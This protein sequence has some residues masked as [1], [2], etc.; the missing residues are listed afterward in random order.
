MMKTM[1][2]L[3]VQYEQ[4]TLTRRQLLQG[5]AVVV[6]PGERQA[7][8]G[9]LRGRNI[10]HVNLRVADVD[11]SVDFYRRLFSL[12][13]RRLIPGRPDVVDLPNG[14]FISFLL[15]DQPGTVDHFDIGVE[16]FD[17]QQT[18]EALRAAGIDEGLVVGPDFVFVTDPD[19]VRVQISTPEWTG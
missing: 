18:G 10:N 8:G 1:D 9:A 11:R 13:P 4:G 6:V 19:S 2:T 15:S 3:L 5:L 16:E 12:P 14:N 7:S 17:P